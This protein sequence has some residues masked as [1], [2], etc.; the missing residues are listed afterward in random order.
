MRVPKRSLM[1]FWTFSVHSQV[2]CSLS[3]IHNRLRATSAAVVSNTAAGTGIHK[4]R[5]THTHTH[6]THTHKT[7][8]NTHTHTHK[9]ICKS[10]SKPVSQSLHLPCQCKGHDST[11]HKTQLSVG[12]R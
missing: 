3:S 1:V 6:H 12:A 5:H 8:T 2:H 9:K 4:H 10:Q 11:E 7:H